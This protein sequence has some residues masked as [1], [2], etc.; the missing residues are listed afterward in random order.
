MTTKFW[1][2]NNWLEK[3]AVSEHWR[4][5]GMHPFKES[6]YGPK[7]N[8][9]SNKIKKE[10]QIHPDYTR[11]IA[12][13]NFRKKEQHPYARE[14]GEELISLGCWPKFDSNRTYWLAKCLKCGRWN[15]FE[16]KYYLM[17]KRPRIKSFES[18]VAEGKTIG[19][20]CYGCADL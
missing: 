12:I 16:L 13:I 9:Y 17:H 15:R 2:S 7:Q 4:V 14:V 20:T 19:C 1:R 3:K 5:C 11:D 6:I 8:G 18:I 10:T